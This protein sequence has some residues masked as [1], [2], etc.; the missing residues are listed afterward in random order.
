MSTFIKI[1][2]VNPPSTRPR[3]DLVDSALPAEGALYLY[4]ATHSGGRW[5]SGVAAGLSI[6]NV[7]AVSAL[8]LT[9]NSLHGS[10]SKGGTAVVARRTTKGGIHLTHP[11][12]AAVKG[13][14]VALEIPTALAEYVLAN[15]AHSYYMSQ[16]TR[17]TRLAVNGGAPAFSSTIHSGSGSFLASLYYNP[18]G[19]NTY[20]Q[21]SL[22][23]DKFISSRTTNYPAV[24]T[25]LL[26]A[27]GVSG[28]YGTV[29][30][31]ASAIHAHPFQLGGIGAVQ[32]GTISPN[33]TVYRCYLEDLT[34]S[35]RTYAQAD[36]AD[37]AAYT[38]ECL[39]PGGRYYGDTH[40]A[41]A[42]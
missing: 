8:K 3:V 12:T 36:A 2:G 6:P 29:P 24:G 37:L 20:P 10:L 18:T 22:G 26:T 13:E 23:A 16:W 28:W 39:T 7:A 9:G 11:E 41:P 40:T 4:D 42:A 34:V 21:P 15:P 19:A 27:V 25:P 38:L 31:T 1:P 5:D 32:A 33:L 35:G 17:P 14:Y 30:A